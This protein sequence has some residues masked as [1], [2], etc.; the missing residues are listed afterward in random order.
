MKFLSKNVIMI[1]IDGGRLDRADNSKI[2]QKLKDEYQHFE[3]DPL[4]F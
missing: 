3:N 1:L 4:N 2:F